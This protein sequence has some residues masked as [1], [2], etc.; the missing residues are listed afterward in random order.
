[1]FHEFDNGCIVGSRQDNFPMSGVT[2]DQAKAYCDWLSKITGQTYRLPN[3]SESDSL[4]G[5]SSGSENTLDYWAGGV[6][7]PDDAERLQKQIHEL[8][9]WAP[10][11]KEVGSFKATS[12]DEPVFDLGGNV[13]EWTVTSD[14]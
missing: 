10:L 12:S 13:A 9:N 8:G 3:S 6:V 4:Y 11:L 7:N 14:G 2:F 1:Q 5:K